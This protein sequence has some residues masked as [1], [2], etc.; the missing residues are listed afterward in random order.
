V[1]EIHADILRRF[2][3]LVGKETLAHTSR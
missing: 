1:E 3:K 2:T